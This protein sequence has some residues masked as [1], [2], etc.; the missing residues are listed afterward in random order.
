MKINFIKQKYQ[1]VEADLLVVPVASG[2]SQK[3]NELDK[4][5]GGTLKAELVRTGFSA[6]LGATLWCDGGDNIKATKICLLGLG[7]Q[8]EVNHEIIRRWAGSAIQKARKV[9]ARRVAIVAPKLDSAD[10]LVGALVEGL[11]LADYRF[12]DYKKEEARKAR[13]RAIREVNIIYDGV[14]GR[15]K[16]VMARTA[17]GVLGA[18]F[19]R[20]LVN[21]PSNMVHPRDLAAVAANIAE[22]SERVNIKTFN[23][24]ALTK[25]GF[26]AILAVAKGSVEE[27]YLIHLIYK[28]SKPLKRITLVGK[29]ITFDSGGLSLKTAESMAEMKVD[30]AG[31]ATVLGVFRALMLADL[32]LEVHGLIPACENMPSGRAARPGDVITS[33]GGKTVEIVNTDAEGRLILAD[34]LAYATKNIKPDIMLDLA[35]LTGAAMVALGE[36]VAALM[37]HDEDLAL[38]ITKAAATTGENIWRLPLVKDYL[39]K[40]RSDIADIKNIH[41]D[42]WAGAIMGGLF[43]QEFVDESTPFAHIDIAGPVWAA[44]NG[45]SYN[46]KG[47]TGFGV[48][49]LL[50]WLRHLTL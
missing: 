26:G 45:V 13:E 6:E 20:D 14:I 17:I 19:A 43:L 38:S 36:T 9:V 42:K 47:A 5:L 8:A 11:W 30:M 21:Q 37:T 33:Y 18:T 40:Y 25:E 2:E 15:A 44:K 32:P 27:P 24:E 22:Q 48:R 7:E 28:G 4:A 10:A 23:R 35:T 1:E 29:G 3:L 46:P 31:A 49:T 12:L 39:P 41:D 50:E 16:E 34:A